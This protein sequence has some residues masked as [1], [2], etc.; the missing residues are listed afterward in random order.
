MRNKLIIIIEQ[1]MKFW[2]KEFLWYYQCFEK[3]EKRNIITS[4]VTSFI[5]LAYEGISSY[6]HNR[7][8]KA[9]HKAFVAMENKGNSEWNRVF[10]LEDSM[11]MYGI[12][13]SDILE[14]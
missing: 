3:K 2:Q 4:L 9:L 7:R 8:Q 1:A 12:Y 13:S 6:L 10:H 11:V 5:G 14:Q